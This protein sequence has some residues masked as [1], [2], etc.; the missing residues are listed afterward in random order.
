MLAL[1]KR[2]CNFVDDLS[3]KRVLYLSL[4]RSQFEHCSVI[5]RP[6]NVTLLTKLESLQRKAVKWI[7]S[8]QNIDYGDYDY[9]H[10]LH[11]LDLLP[12]DNKF[13]FTDLILFHRI[14]HKKICI[15]LPSYLSLFS[16]GS[17][18]L[19]NTHMDPLSFVSNIQPRINKTVNSRYEWESLDEFKDSYF[20]RV[21]LAW[22]KLPL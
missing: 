2:N 11:S 22:N 6:H 9:I 12:L 16:V 13:N 15:Q 19:R 14:I 3:Q 21:H 1:V 7:L 5:W 4:V 17:S 8:E 18:R 10:R 20:Y